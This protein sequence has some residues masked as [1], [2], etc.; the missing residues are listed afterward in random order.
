MP[1]RPTKAGQAALVKIW[2]FGICSTLRTALLQY[3]QACSTANVLQAGSLAAALQTI[4]GYIARSQCQ[5]TRCCFYS[6]AV[7]RNFS[8]VEVLGS[9]PSGSRPDLLLAADWLRSH[10]AAFWRYILPI[11]IA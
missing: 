6:S 1:A 3:G 2:V 4:W 7:E 5:V 11:G 8:K 9:N 10:S